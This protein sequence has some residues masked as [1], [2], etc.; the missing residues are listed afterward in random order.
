MCKKWAPWAGRGAL[1]GPERTSCSCQVC[2]GAV[3]RESVRAAAGALEEEQRDQLSALGTWGAH[4]GL[5][6]CLQFPFAGSVVCVGAIQETSYS[7]E[8][9]GF[10]V[11]ALQGL[12]A[13]LF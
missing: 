6:E 5:I 11:E 9:C 4:G 13:Y 8:S 3:V 12:A 7:L 10:E 1:R 2:L